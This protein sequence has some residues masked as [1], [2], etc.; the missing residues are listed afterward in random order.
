[1]AVANTSPGP[2]WATAG[3]GDLAMT[4]TQLA[5]WTHG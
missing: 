1:M 4:P 3:N 2:F 5:R